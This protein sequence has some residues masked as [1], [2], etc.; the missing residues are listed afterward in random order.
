MIWFSTNRRRFCASSSTNFAVSALAPI[1]SRMAF[2]ALAWSSALNTGERTS[3]A[4]VG[5]G[6]QGA[7]QARQIGAHRVHRAP[8]LGQFKQGMGVTPCQSAFRRF[9]LPLVILFAAQDAN[10]RQAAG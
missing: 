8:I 5:A 9:P 7:A 6:L 4:Q 10:A 1:L 2:K 3:R